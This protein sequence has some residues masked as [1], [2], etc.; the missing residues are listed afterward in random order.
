[1]PVI[2]VVEGE[3]LLSVSGIIAGVDVQKND[4]AV[5]V[6][7]IDVEE[8][9]IIEKKGVI[10][11]GDRILKATQGRLRR[12]GLL[13]VGRQSAS[14]LEKGVMAQECGIVLIFVAKDDLKEALTDLLEPRVTDFVG[15]SV[16]RNE[17]C[18]ALGESPS[19]I[20]L[21]EKKKTPVRRE[22][23]SIK[24]DRDRLVDGFQIQRDLVYTCCHLVI[25]LFDLE[26]TLMNQS[27]NKGVHS[28]KV[29]HATG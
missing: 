21:L 5:R 23:W 11:H 9:K 18:E 22:V 3:C 7:R 15:V 20:D 28:Q 10:T 1:M 29:G 2:S 27:S 13:G 6:K 8:F 14:G 16:V 19:L 24:S 26:N 12:E 4:L 17:V 25:L